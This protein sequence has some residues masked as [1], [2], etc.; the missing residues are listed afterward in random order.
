MVKKLTSKAKCNYSFPC[1]LDPLTIPSIKAQWRSDNQLVPKIS[2]SIFIKYASQKKEGS[3]G[4]QEKAF[5]MLQIVTVKV[6][7]EDPNSLYV[8]AM[9]KKSYDHESRPVIIHFKD[10][11]P[12]QARCKCPVDTSGLCCHALAL[13]LFLKHFHESGENVL[14]LT[15][16][17]KLQKWHSRMNKGSIP[18]IPLKDIK[19]GFKIEAADPEKSS[20]KRN[21]TAVINDLIKK[22]DKEKLVT[23]YLYSI[24]NR[25]LCKAECW[26]PITLVE[27]Y[28]QSHKF[29]CIDVCLSTLI[30]VKK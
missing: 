10:D 26:A 30:S 12:Y 29:W 5:R 24:L 13:L 9:I 17:E 18:M 25:Y 16:T 2:Q 3:Q 7:V 23:E 1:S 22:L 14:E 20:F 21:I 11:F 15:C 6:F 27:S 28:N 19:T 8:K 4:H